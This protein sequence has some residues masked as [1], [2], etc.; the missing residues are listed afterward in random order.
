MSLK[1]TW[2]L[3]IMTMKNDTKFEKEV[4]T[5]QFK[6]YMRNLTNFDLNTQKSQKFALS[7]AAFEQSI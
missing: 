1:F 2:E 4:T 6:I 5:G 3:C 7:G